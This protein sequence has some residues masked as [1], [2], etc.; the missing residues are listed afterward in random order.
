MDL[1]NKYVEHIKNE[2]IE[3]LQFKILQKYS[4]KISHAYYLGLDLDFTTVI[5]GKIAPDERL[6]KGL[7]SYKTL[8]DGLN[9]EYNNIVKTT[10][11]HTDKIA[12]V[13]G[14]INENE[15]D[16][17]VEK[18]QDVD[19]LI[20]DK[21]QLILS[22]TNA[23]CILLMFYDPIKNVIGN[24][25]SGWKGTLQ[26]ISVK[27]VN[28]MIEEYGCNPQ[29]IICCMSPNIRKDHFEVSKDVKDMFYKE[30]C[31]L[32]NI[33]EL[34]EET[35]QSEKWHIDTIEINREILRKLGLKEENIVDSKLCSVCN[36]E[37]IHS[38]RAEGITYGLTTAVIKLK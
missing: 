21:K 6:K 30:F 20:T 38:Y 11:T 17:N 26:R 14:K 18:Y 10:Q 2:K 28:K 15:P 25:H 3:Y 8:C 1:T 37:I 13:T 23:D 16:I 31:D 27:T 34:I 24:S 12:K 36:K 19:G 4:N 5:Q 22:T 7:N 29:D 35:V 9:E 32:E 33:N